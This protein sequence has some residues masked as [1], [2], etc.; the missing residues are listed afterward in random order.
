MK[1]PSMK[2]LAMKQRN[3]RA[4]LAG[5][6]LIV[7]VN[8]VVL[9]GVAYNR[10]GEAESTVT[11]TERELNLPY[12]YGRS[13]E[14]SGIALRFNY[15]SKGSSVSNYRYYGN[16]VK[17]LT[18]E[19]LAELGFDATQPLKTNANGNDYRR[20]TEKEVILVLE[21]NGEAYQAALTAAQKHLDEIKAE[22][23][24][25]TADWRDKNKLKQAE[26]NLKHEQSSASRLFVINAGL[27]Q[28][29]LRKQYP[30]NKKY[31]LLK[32]LVG[33]YISNIKNDAGTNVGTVSGYLKGLS[34]QTLHIPLEH[35][36]VLEEAMAEESRLPRGEAPRYEVT[37]N[38]GKRLEPWVVEVKE[39]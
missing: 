13:S 3:L 24:A 28:Q 20:K 23:P 34:I 19:K 27:D 25:D 31:L 39:I 32:G 9:A 10:S 36:H 29:A 16:D 11:L 22:A 6:G 30:D 38:I 2:A 21:Y 12:R 18:K 15:R 14:N 7:V 35:H 5:I 8:A 37:L 17:W 33:V 1:S 4:L 26:T